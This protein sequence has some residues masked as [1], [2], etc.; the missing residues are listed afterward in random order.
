MSE[1]VKILT[2]LPHSTGDCIHGP[3]IKFSLGE[4]ELTYDY[5]S[6]SGEQWAVLRF[7]RALAV[8]FTPDLAV[9]A[10]MIKAYSKV[11]WMDDSVWLMQTMQS[12][13]DHAGTIPEDTKHLLLYFDHY[14]CV[15]VLAQGVEILK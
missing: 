3:A 11:C 7:V 8:K 12:A 5:L 6:G 1:Q 13:A 10:E 9:S 2:V 15:E 4:M 14:G